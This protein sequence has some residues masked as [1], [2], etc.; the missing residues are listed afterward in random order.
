[1]YNPI[2][3]MLGRY[4]NL[5]KMKTKRLS[6]TLANILFTIEHRQ[7]KMFKLINVTIL[8]TK[9]AHFKFDACYRSQIVGTG[10]C[11]PWCSISYS[12]QNSLKTSGHR[13]LCVSGVLVLE[14]G[15]AL[16]C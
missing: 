1:M 3:E 6:I 7:H 14:F 15:F 13:G 5:N 11:L 8:C 4:L 10:A 9:L 12:F 16:S 2:P